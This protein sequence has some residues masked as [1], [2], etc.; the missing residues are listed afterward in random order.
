MKCYRTGK[1][2]DQA[3]FESPKKS[4]IN[5]IWS[6]VRRANVFSPKRSKLNQLKVI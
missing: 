2:I 6:E 1:L 5:R 3:Y 4:T